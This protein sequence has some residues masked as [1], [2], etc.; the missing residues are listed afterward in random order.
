MENYEQVKKVE[1]IIAL[2]MLVFVVAVIFAVYSFVVVGRQKRTL[3]DYNELVAA[4][5]EEKANLESQNLEISSEEYLEELAR[6]ELGMIKED[7]TVYIFN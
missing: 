6:G 5:E 1:K 3:A 4:L 2:C 7:E